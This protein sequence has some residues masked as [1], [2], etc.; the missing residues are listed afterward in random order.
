MRV[1]CT[2]LQRHLNQPVSPYPTIQSISAPG[3]VQI[4]LDGDGGS[5]QG[6]GWHNPA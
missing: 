2:T 1:V 4:V 3:I 5:G 6:S